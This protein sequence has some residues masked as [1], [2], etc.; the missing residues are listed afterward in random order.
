MSTLK[1]RQLLLRSIIKACGGPT[2]LESV[3]GIPRQN[4]T[5]WQIRGKVPAVIAAQIAR[6]LGISKWGFNY[7]DFYVIYEVDDEPLAWKEV[8]ESY[9]LP[10]DIVEEL[11]KDKKCKTKK[12]RNKKSAKKK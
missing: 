7:S 1:K 6:D 2:E 11:L 12:K 8:V 10:K 5:N 9:L 4:F 3:T